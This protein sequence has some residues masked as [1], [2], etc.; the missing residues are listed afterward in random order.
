MVRYRNLSNVIT[1]CWDLMSI[2]T[3]GKKMFRLINLVAHGRFLVVDFGQNATKLVRFRIDWN[4]QKL[5]QT[6][7]WSYI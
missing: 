7:E 1:V 5:Q 3:S 4:S 2:P 6:I